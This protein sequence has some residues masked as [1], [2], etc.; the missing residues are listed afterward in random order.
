MALF[1]LSPM[2]SYITNVHLSKLNIN[3][4]NYHQFNSTLHLDFISFSIRV[5]L[6]LQNPFQDPFHFP[7]PFC[8][9]IKFFKNVAGYFFFNLF[10]CFW[11][12]QVFVAVLR[13]RLVVV[14]RGYSWLRFTGFSQQWI[15]L[16]QSSGSR[17]T[18]FSYFNI[19][20]GS[21][22]VAH[23]L[24]GIEPMCPALAGGFLPTVPPG[25]SFPPFSLN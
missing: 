20:M 2:L 13:L 4:D 8:F 21:V 12:H 1:Q 9:L 5:L 3:M 10:T 23:G 24:S 15:L 11:L 18:G 6:P 17:R 19:Y 25:K 16:Q 7:T 22:V 14:S